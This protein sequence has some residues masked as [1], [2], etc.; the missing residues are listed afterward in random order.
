MLVFAGGNLPLNVALYISS[1][2]RTDTYRGTGP[3][4]G[5]QRTPRQATVGIPR[6]FHSSKEPAAMPTSVGG[7][8]TY[9][10]RNLSVYQLLYA[11]KMKLQG[12]AFCGR[13][14]EGLS[15]RVCRSTQM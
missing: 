9:P 15:G 6:S 4:G 10:G 8:K 12:A 5:R 1:M 14:V 3:G 7:N 2:G 13:F 11:A